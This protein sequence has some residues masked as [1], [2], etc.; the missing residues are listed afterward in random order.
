MTSMTPNEPDKAYAAYKAQQ[1][2]DR[3]G[4]SHPKDFV[5]EDLAFALGVTVIEAPLD[6]AE[7]RL[8]RKGTRGLIRLRSGIPE[9]GRKRFAV[10]HE[11]GHWL[12]HEKIS[13]ILACTN[14]DIYS[15]YKASA[16]ELEASAFGAELLMPERLFQVSMRGSE[17]TLATIR[18]LADEF[19][20]SLTAT[21]IR[22]VELCDECCALV[23]SEAGK[24]RWWRRSREFRGQFW[25]A[26]GAE[27]PAQSAAAILTR[28]GPPER[29]MEIPIETWLTNSEDSI[30]T[31]VVE[32][33]FRMERYGQ[34]L[35]FLRIPR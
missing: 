1:L 21:A 29:P 3:Y 10:A 34:V 30:A 19:D 2:W 25:L 26:P 17:F 15:T 22:F 32:E 18:K 27:L 33:V 13:Q 16:P 5:L 35:S 14:Q 28:A 23:V 12:M 31:T 6:S 8:L 11:L 20:T 24:V 4:F 7:A 9:R